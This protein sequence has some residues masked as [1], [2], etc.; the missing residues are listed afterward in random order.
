LNYDHFGEN[1]KKWESGII[2]NRGVPVIQGEWGIISI[3]RD[4]RTVLKQPNNGLVPG[5]ERPMNST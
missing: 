2:I 1:G 4:T 5:I 3:M